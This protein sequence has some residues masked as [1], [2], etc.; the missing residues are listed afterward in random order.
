MG[1]V[2]NGVR[3]PRVSGTEAIAEELSNTTGGP[4]PDLCA[5]SGTTREPANRNIILEYYFVGVLFSRLGLG[6]SVAGLPRGFTALLRVFVDFG[7]F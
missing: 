6:G 7:D 1:K 3:M 4:V 5:G 2:R